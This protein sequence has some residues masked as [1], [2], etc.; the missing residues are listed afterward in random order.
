[1]SWLRAVFPIILEENRTEQNAYIYFK[2]EVNPEPIC[3]IQH[4][5]D[6]LLYFSPVSY[7]NVSL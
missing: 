2:V 7:M 4:Y 5:V 1:M 6:K 3:V